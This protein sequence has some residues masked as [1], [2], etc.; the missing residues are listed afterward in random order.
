VSG[1]PSDFADILVAAEGLLRREQMAAVQ[2]EAE[3]TGQAL[4]D[5]VVRMGLCTE[6]QLLQ[7]V[8]RHLQVRFVTFDDMEGLSSDVLEA[9]PAKWAA[10]YRVMPVA[11]AEDSLTVAVSDPF[12]YAGMDDLRLVLDGRSLDIV[13]ATSEDI[14]KAQTRF[15]GIGA[16]TADQLLAEGRTGRSAVV[17]SARS[18]ED[19]ADLDAATEASVAKFVNLILLE[20]LKERATDIHMEP[21]EDHF[22]VRYRVDGFLHDASVPPTIKHFR[23]AIVSRIKVMADLNIAERR[24]PQDG[25]INIT[26]ASDEFDLRVSVLPST[27]G[28]AVNIRI[29]NRSSGA[30]AM[31]ELGLGNDDLDKMQWLIRQ[32]HGIVLV[33]GPTGSG[34]TTSLYASLSRINTPEKKILTI[35]DPVEYRIP[36]VVQMQVHP[37]IGFTFSSALRH[38]LRHDPD[39]IMVGEIRDLETSRIAIRTALTGHLVFST[40]HTND[41]AGAVSRLLDMEVEPFLVASSVSCIIAQRLVRTICPDCKQPDE[42]SVVP[43]ELADSDPSFA[44]GGRRLLRGVG[45]ESCRFTGYR[46][47]TGIFEI[48]MVD[49]DIRSLIMS[50]APATAIKEQAQKAGMRTLREAAWAKVTAGRTT[51]EELVR[52]VEQV[53]YA[54][55]ENGE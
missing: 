35:E 31:E 6:R 15:Y 40:L 48:L 50:R 51:A 21:F 5:V 4:T 22:R 29:L 46:G 23:Q 45:C 9:L 53:A 41:A 55:P 42:E 11:V 32:P 28:E 13:L 38:I 49:E 2:A 17:Q 1:S 7:V 33:T 36:G 18:G 47:R 43:A 3:R 30:L 12:D 10:F 20:A 24:L 39:V 25:R 34:K 26:L 19:L 27:F 8:S 44:A 54:P 14:R 37:E 52:V 16:D